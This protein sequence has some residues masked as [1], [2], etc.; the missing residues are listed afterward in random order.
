MDNTANNNI[1]IELRFSAVGNGNV[2]LNVRLPEFN[3]V[4]SYVHRFIRIFRNNKFDANLISN[5]VN[6]ATGKKEFSK[7]GFCVKM[8]I[9]TEGNKISSI[10]KWKPNLISNVVLKILNAGINALNKEQHLNL[11]IPQEDLM[12]SVTLIE[13]QID[14]IY[15]KNMIDVLNNF[16]KHIHEPE[17]Q[18]MLNSVSVIQFSRQGEGSQIY[19]IGDIDFGSVKCVL[20]KKAFSPRNM[21][22]ILA[23][24]YSYN[25]PGVPQMIATIDQWAAVGRKVVR[26][27]PLNASKPIGTK[28]YGLDGVQALTGM[29]TNKALNSGDKGLSQTFKEL[30]DRVMGN[31]SYTLVVYYDISDTIV[32]DNQLWDYFSSEIMQKGSHMKNFNH[33]FND[34]SIE[35][36]SDNEKNTLGQLQKQEN[37][38]EL[39]KELEK[40]KQAESNFIDNPDNKNYLR[41]AIR[42]LI[43]T[44][45]RNGNVTII[46]KYNDTANAL[47]DVPDDFTNILWSFFSHQAILDRQKNPNI[48][49]RMIEVCVDTTELILNVSAIDVGRKWDDIS[50]YFDNMDEMISMANV[51]GLVIN[52]VNE[53]RQQG[54]VA[55]GRRYRKLNESN[56]FSLEDFLSIFGETPQS[57]QQK[58]DKKEEL[59]NEERNIKNSFDSM[60]NRIIEANK[61]NHDVIW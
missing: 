14:S 56:G 9:P 18:K 39:Q 43:S 2:Y 28:K 53:I 25:K 46:P 37:D 36:M 59:K 48:R 33:E 19:D 24:W 58:F 13:G 32:D 15:N 45:D 20:A 7:N 49:K 21:Q 23:Q 57:L 12:N 35:Q 3:Q 26:N 11:T 51:I 17:V 54:T 31:G 22:W 5:V 40:R 10:R 61:K 27:F 4:E 8:P 41:E 1:N 60:W 6:D 38:D 52:K 29:D 30:A 34:T 16:F 44:N 47:R 42:Q 55:E 50:K